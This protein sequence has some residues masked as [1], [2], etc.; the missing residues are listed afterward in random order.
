MSHEPS[1]ARIHS[2]RRTDGRKGT[3]W[4]KAHTPLASSASAPLPCVRGRTHACGA[5][6]AASCR[7][8][9]KQRAALTRLTTAAMHLTG[10]CHFSLVAPLPRQLH[11]K[12]RPATAALRCSRA[13]ARHVVEVACG[14]AP[15]EHGVRRRARAVVAADRLTEA[16]LV[17]HSAAAASIRMP[18]S[19]R[20]ELTCCFAQDYEIIKG[21][22]VS[23]DSAVCQP[24]TAVLVH[25]NIPRILELSPSSP[26]SFPAAA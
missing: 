21:A 4:T 23:N 26:P 9:L 5:Q 1:P 3:A 16:F 15:R 11:V 17:C 8:G 20:P 2:I 7:L 22:L 10:S 14:V 25:G 19:R 12:A 24:P 13:P 18:E 6:A